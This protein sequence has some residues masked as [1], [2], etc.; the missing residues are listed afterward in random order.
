MRKKIILPAHFGADLTIECLIFVTGPFYS[1]PVK[2]KIGKFSIE[3]VTFFAG[4]LRNSA[5]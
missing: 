5:I 2:T 3:A 1:W 4:S